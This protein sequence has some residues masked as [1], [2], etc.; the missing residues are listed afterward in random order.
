MTSILIISP[1]DK[2]QENINKKI[3][4]LNNN[5][6]IFIGLNKTQKSTEQILLKEKIDIDRIFFIDCVTNEKTKEEVLHIRPEDL[7]T[8]TEASTIF[9]KEIKGNKFLIIDSLSTLLI[10]NSENKV[11]KFVQ[12]ITANASSYNVE[13]IAFSP[14]TQGE[15]LLEKIFNF[16]DKVEKIN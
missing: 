7:E 9:M 13:I 4:E 15:E 16:F 14:Q 3:K 1:V 12:E 10:Y 6:G 8:L 11:A 2:L 5:F